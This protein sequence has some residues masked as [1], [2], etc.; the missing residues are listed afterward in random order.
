MKV[1]DTVSSKITHTLSANVENLTLTGTAAINATG[2]GLANVI[3][4]N[5]AANQLTSGTGNDIF[6]FI[7]KGPSDKITDYNVANDTVQLENAAFTAL[8][9][10][11]TLNASQFKIG[12]KALD[13]ND[14]IIYNKT[15]GTLL[16]DAD[17]SGAAAATQIATI[18]VGLN[19]T[20][21]DIVV[22]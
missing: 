18:G 10:T 19:M 20:N 15:A 1:L 2:N 4:G 5:S 14:F 9:T 3:T 11:G 8:T 7:T 16:Y 6:K 22:I 21:A 12:T 13:A 17:G